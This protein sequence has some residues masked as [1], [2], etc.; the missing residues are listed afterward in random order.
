MTSADIENIEDQP[1]P[2]SISGLG[3]TGLE[4]E[5]SNGTKFSGDSDFPEF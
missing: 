5:L 3:E 4:R 2:S 1:C